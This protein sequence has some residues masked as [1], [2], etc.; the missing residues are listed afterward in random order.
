M[1]TKQ[2]RQLPR[3]KLLLGTLK[4]LPPILRQLLTKLKP[5][6]I[7]LKPPLQKQKLV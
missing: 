2:K 4:P 7:A 1:P 5:L 6:R 3:L